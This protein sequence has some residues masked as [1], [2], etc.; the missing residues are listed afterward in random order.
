MRRPLVV[1]WNKDKT[2]SSPTPIGRGR[3][4]RVSNKYFMEKNLAG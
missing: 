3:K 2:I 4:V 1:V